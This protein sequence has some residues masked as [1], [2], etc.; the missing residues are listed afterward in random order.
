M[1][2]QNHMLSL[3][4]GSIN[5]IRCFASNQS[6]SKRSNSLEIHV[7]RWKDPRGVYRCRVDA[8]SARTSEDMKNFPPSVLKIRLDWTASAF[9][10]IKY[11]FL[12]Y[13]KPMDTYRTL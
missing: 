6:S 1:A 11:W 3:E 12:T 7:Y 8:R 4:P 10:Q 9:R 13:W 5:Q 2:R